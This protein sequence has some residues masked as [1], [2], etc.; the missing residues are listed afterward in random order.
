MRVYPGGKRYYA[1]SA[2]LKERFGCRVYR[3]AV[4]AG[5]TCPNRD[6]RV[7]TGGCVYCDARGSGAR[8][9]DRTSSVGEQV[10]RGAKFALERYRAEK[11]IVY[12][13]AFTNTYAPVDRLRRLYDEG[14]AQ[15]DVVGL[16]IGTRPD[17]VPE[18]VLDLIEGYARD[19]EAWIEYG[20]QSAKDETLRRINRGHDVRA[21]V[22]AVERT[23]GRGIRICAHVI[24]GLPGECREDMM[25]TARL[26]ADLGLD[27][28]K[29]HPLHVLRGT[30]AEEMYRRGTLPLLG[31]GEYVGL[32]CDFL[33]RV[34]S[35]TVIQ[36]LTGEGPGES[37]LA[38]PWCASKPKVLQAIDAEL[39][40]RGTGQG[41]RSGGWR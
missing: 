27:G 25:R 15:E 35:D 30:R 6:G 10:R 29:I 41:M 36:R 19:R 32:L 14:M 26:L 12:F 20:L 31:Q 21:F 37:M 22:D 2:Y 40:R 33:E 16:A 34:P 1:F 24:L 9:A 23:R 11:F 39:E 7:G 13:Q 8:Y 38:P 5:F 18:P 4:D 28:V 3:V 17:C